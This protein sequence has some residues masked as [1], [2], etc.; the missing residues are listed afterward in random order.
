M[1]RVLITGSGGTP[2]TNFVRSLR[3]SSEP[4]YIIG[5]DADKFSLMRSETDEK[6][7][8]PLA[9][10]SDYTDMINDI[11]DE[12]RA[13]FVHAQPDQ[14]VEVLSRNRSKIRAMTFLPS[15]KTVEVLQDK[16]KSYQAWTKKGIK[17]PKT[18]IINNEADLKKAFEELGG[19]LWIR[20]IS[21]AFGKGSIPTTSFD[22]ARTWIEFKGG[23]G[24]F[25]A[26]ERLTPNS[27]TWLSI[28]KDGELVVAQSRKR[29][30]WELGNR[31]PSGVTGITGTGVIVD[32]EQVNKIALDSIYAVDSKPNG[33]FGVDLTYDSADIPNPTEI[34]IGR[35]FT[36]HLFF[37]RAGLNMPH[38]YVRL[39][40]NESVP[41]IP[42]KI[43]PLT[44]NMCWIRGMDFNPVLTTM[45][46]VDYE[47]DRLEKRR[48]R[49]K[50][51]V[52]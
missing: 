7:L 39:A 41:H 14:E 19:N 50:T 28:W 32:D 35:F 48:L 31:A 46:A 22:L 8:V 12:T 3:E 25:T 13:E 29:L 17:T 43:N 24:R 4:F 23:W 51:K 38:I 10:E 11:I 16:W 1:K 33:I 52:Q 5:T 40:Y 45:G 49:L 18:V 47:E 9:S 27:V 20:E 37:T 6:H 42:K 34:N 26:A 2:S 44:P 36:T 30:Y 21:G 15:E